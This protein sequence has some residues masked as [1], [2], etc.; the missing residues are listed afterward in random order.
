SGEILYQKPENIA[1]HDL[2]N[3]FIGE[4]F[5][6][7]RVG[8]LH[9]PACVERRL[10]RAV[11]I[12]AQPHVIHANKIRRVTNRLCYRL[13]IRAA[14]RGVPVADSNHAAGSRNALELL[15]TKISLVP[16]T[17]ECETNT[18]RV[19]IASTSSIVFAEACA[20]ST[21]IRLDSMRRIISLPLS[22]R[23]PLSTPC[24]EPPMSL[25]KKCVGAIMRKPASNNRS[26]L[27]RLPSSA[28]APSMPRKPAVMCGSVILR[29]R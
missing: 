9:K 23:P 14:H 8:D 25:S 11:E 3:L 20:T 7:E 29:S 18:G 10:D 6:N 19:A 27:S 12:R 15:I 26:T 22:V 4:S 24:A 13:R 28:C 5:R 21:I 2:S 1:T 16:L 17:P